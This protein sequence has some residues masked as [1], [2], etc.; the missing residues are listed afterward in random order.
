TRPPPGTPLLPYTTLFR[1]VPV[2]EAAQAGR[3][4]EGQHLD[5]A[6][7]RVAGLPGRVD[8]SQHGLAGGRVE[9]ADRAGVD[10]GSV[11]RPRPWHQRSEEH[12]SELQS[13]TNLVCP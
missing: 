2:G 5:D 7:Q 11:L 4:P 12:T 13:L 6:A 9:T 1:S 3:Q 8:L 10:D